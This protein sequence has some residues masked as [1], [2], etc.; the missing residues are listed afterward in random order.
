MLRKVDSITLCYYM[1]PYNLAIFSVAS[2]AVE[3]IQPVRP[4]R[5]GD[6]SVGGSGGADRECVVVAG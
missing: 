5:L 1:A 3:G 4:E 2:A 6:D